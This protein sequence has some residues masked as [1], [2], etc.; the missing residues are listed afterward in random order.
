MIA[1]KYSKEFAHTSL[2]KPLMT[3]MK[4]TGC[5]RVKAVKVILTGNVVHIHVTGTACIT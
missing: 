1:G 4:E 3:A 2:L 5:I